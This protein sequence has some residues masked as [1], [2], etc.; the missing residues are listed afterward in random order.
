M[1]ALVNPIDSAGPFDFEVPEDG[2]YGIQITATSH[3]SGTTLSA[4][5]FDYADWTTITAD[6]RA[7]TF[8]FAGTLTVTTTGSPSGVNVKIRKSSN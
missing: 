2:W 8:L 4:D 5:G 1:A 3:G 6:T 7:V